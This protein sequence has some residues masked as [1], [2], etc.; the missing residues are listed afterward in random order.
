MS[1]MS[2]NQYNYI[3]DMNNTKSQNVKLVIAMACFNAV[4][5]LLASVVI[6]KL[7][8][9]IISGGGLSPAVPEQEK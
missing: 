4:Q 3:A 7:Q 1:I 8:F 6:L 5:I 9:A 2:I